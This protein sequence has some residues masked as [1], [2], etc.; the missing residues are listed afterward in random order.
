MSLKTKAE[1][2]LL[3]Q[4]F[5][6]AGRLSHFLS[7]NSSF[8]FTGMSW[9]NGRHMKPWTS[10]YPLCSACNHHSTCA[11]PLLF[12]FWKSGPV[13]SFFLFRKDWDQD[14]SMVVLEQSW[15]SLNQSWPGKTDEILCE[16]D[17]MQHTVVVWEMVHSTKYDHIYVTRATHFKNT[18]KKPVETLFQ[19]CFCQDCC[20]DY[21]V[22]KTGP[23]LVIGPT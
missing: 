22:I 15:T 7:L 6:S 12:N 23:R 14:Q 10:M 9:V 19:A 18:C 3:S 1:S 13:W 11:I 16:Y 20:S 21:Y 8:Y 2:Y 5:E 17:V 4:Y